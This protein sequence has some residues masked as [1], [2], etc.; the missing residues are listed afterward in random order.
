MFKQ[1]KPVRD[2]GIK[3]FLTNAQLL[4]EMPANKKFKELVVPELPFDIQ[5][6]SSSSIYRD[7]RRMY[8]DLGG[9]FSPRVCSTMR[10]L[11]TQDL[12]KD[13][14]QYSPTL[15]ELIWFKDHGYIY[16]DAAEEIMALIRFSEISIFHE[17]NHRIFWRRLPRCP[18]DEPSVLRYLDFAE[19]L[20]VTLDMAFADQLGRRAST[21]FE[22][23]KVIYHPGGFDK[24]SEKS[25]A[26]YRQYLLAILT[27]TYFAMQTMHYDDLF[28]AVNYVLPGQK[29]MN[30]VAVNRALQLSELFTRV[31]NPQWQSA[32]WQSGRNKLKK[33]HSKS[34]SNFLK[35]P[36]DPL[37]LDLELE[38]ALELFEYFGL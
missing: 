26:E 27:T 25:K 30:R 23:M 32:N 24:Y 5:L 6:L 21:A 29:K 12:F 4:F 28:D 22:K 11:S 9:Q 14:I 13:E 37:D 17:Q 36:A 31:T 3:E 34:N 20:V 19:S 35:L 7:S 18:E 33:L 15:S 8:L 38:M 16:G 2:P 1:K 10:G